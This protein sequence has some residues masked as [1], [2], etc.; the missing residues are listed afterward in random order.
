[1][2]FIFMNSCVEIN[3]LIES[4]SW[5]TFTQ[6]HLHPQGVILTHNSFCRREI[7][8]QQI[9]EEGK[10]IDRQ[11]RTLHVW[12]NI[13][14]RESI[15]IHVVVGCRAL[16]SD[17]SSFL[18]MSCLSSLQRITCLPLSFLLF[19]NMKGFLHFVSRKSSRKSLFASLFLVLSC[20][21]IR[22]GN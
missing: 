7:P 20:F 10:G 14:E 9:K 5:H 1:M 19:S 18:I 2:E 16:L 17:P 12:Q 8:L 6:T 13:R 3:S 11:D 22:L 15:V 4:I 21:F